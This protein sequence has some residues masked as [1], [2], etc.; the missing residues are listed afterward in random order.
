MKRLFRKDITGSVMMV[1]GA[2]MFAVM[3]LFV[4]MA[5]A[6]VPFGMTPG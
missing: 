6:T 2:V 3:A 5:S 4:R 1:T